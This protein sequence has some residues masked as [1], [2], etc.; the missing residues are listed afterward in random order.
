MI[1]K[2]YQ[3]F[4]YGI[5]ISLYKLNEK[6]HESK[7][8]IL[9]IDDC[10]PISKM[11]SMII[12]KK[13]Y[14]N[15]YELSGEMGL[16]NINDKWCEKK[17]QYNIMLLDEAI[18]IDKPNVELGGEAPEATPSDDKPFDDD[19]PFDA[20]VEADEETDPKKFIEQLTGKLGQSLRKYNEEQ[21][22][23]DF[24]LEKFVVNSVLSATH[25][26]E[27]DEDDK[28]DIIK[29]VNTAGNDESNDDGNS[30]DDNATD[31]GDNEFSG[32]DNGGDMGN[33]EFSG[34]EELEETVYENFFLDKPKKFP[35][36][37][38]IVTNSFDIC[39][40]LLY[41][42]LFSLNLDSIKSPYCF[43]RA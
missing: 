5:I 19:E 23:P 21:G 10:P 24:D 43:S 30:S 17:N 1:I 29:K 28:K 39:N 13:G 22:Q 3:V 20:G 37:R 25:T 34:E 15:K 18:C 7:I 8:E 36:L 33:D 40:S 9:I 6:S 11:T 42:I 4:I 27:M 41:F 2:N 31:N 16:K 26:S 35:S 32:D 12:D 38:L 14:N